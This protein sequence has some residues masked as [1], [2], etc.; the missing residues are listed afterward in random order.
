MPLSASELQ[1]FQWHAYKIF[2]KCEVKLYNVNPLI[3]ERIAWYK[4]Q[5]QNLFHVTIKYANVK[6]LMFKSAGELKSKLT[7]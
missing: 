4:M 3:T 7:S 5:I 1:D 6:R 2:L